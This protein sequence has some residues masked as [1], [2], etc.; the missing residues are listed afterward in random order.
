MLDHPGVPPAEGLACVEQEGDRV[1]AVEGL[2]RA[3]VEFLAEHVVGLVKARGVHQH[4]LEILAGEHGAEA[5]ARR[6]GGVAGDGQ[7]LAHD[8]VDERALAGVRPPDERDE[9][10][11]E[12]GFGHSES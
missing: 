10:G 7:L 1:D 2:D 5:V 8:R 11:T 4:E 9:A 6:L 3:F 12:D